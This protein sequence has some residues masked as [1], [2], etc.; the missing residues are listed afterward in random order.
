MAE[1]RPGNTLLLLNRESFRDKIFHAGEA[2][3]L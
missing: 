3:A 2:V 1:I